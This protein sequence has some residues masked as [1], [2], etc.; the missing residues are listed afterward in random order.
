MRACVDARSLSLPLRGVAQIEGSFAVA[1]S[2]D[3]AQFD[4]YAAKFMLP[5]WTCIRPSGNPMD[6]KLWKSMLTS[7]DIKTTQMQL[8]SV[9]TCKIFADGKAALVTYTT[10]DIFEYKGTPNEDIAKWS[11][12]CE[13]T[14][15]GWKTV[16]MHRASGQPAASTSN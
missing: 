3:A 13:K 7:E 1:K 9:D 16:H 15:D 10:H 12:T 4:A 14:A 11:V 8:K 5:D 2:K 6:L